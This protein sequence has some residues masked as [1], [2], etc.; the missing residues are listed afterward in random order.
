MIAVIGWSGD[1]KGKIK[2]QTKTFETQSNR[3]S[4]GKKG[5]D[6]NRLGEK[7]KAKKRQKPG[8]LR[9]TGGTR[10]AI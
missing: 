9:K 10:E 6:K 5:E 1:R 2:T 7:A 4:R 8:T 3:G